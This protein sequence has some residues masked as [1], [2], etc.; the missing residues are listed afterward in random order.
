MVTAKLVVSRAMPLDLPK[1]A[2]GSEVQQVFALSLRADGSTFVDGTAT[3][4][5]EDLLT[6]A[7]TSAEKRRRAAR[8]RTSRRQRP[9]PPRD[10]RARCL[11]AS[12]ALARGV[13]RAEGSGGRDGARAVTSMLDAPAAGAPRG[14]ARS[15]SGHR[16]RARLARAGRF[17]LGAQRRGRA[18]KS[19]ARNRNGGGRATRRARAAAASR[20]ART[21]PRPRPTPSRRPPPSRHRQRHRRKILDSSQD[22]VDFG[23]SFV[24]GTGDSFAGGVT[25]TA[26]TS[27]TA[28][29]DTTARG[30]SGGVKPAP[31]PSSPPVD[32]SRPP[33]LAGGVSWQCPFPAEARRRRHR[34]RGRDPA[35]RSARRR[36]GA[37]RD[38]PPWIRVTASV[39]KRGAAPARNIGCPVSTVQANR[40]A[41]A[42]P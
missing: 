34:S 12:R 16:R 33:K 39:A 25:D 20:P 5:D 21:R 7:Q 10:A 1:A 38:P 11:A 37:K 23:N 2:T 22:V 27:T 40:K 26:G 42:R 19:A 32:L 35:G 14:A 18:P 29:R 36:L 31:V 28:V 30:D 6:R 41:P 4:S 17:A 8:G 15:H 9:P 24:T 3:P 13:R